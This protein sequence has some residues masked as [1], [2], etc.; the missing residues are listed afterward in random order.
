RRMSSAPRVECGGEGFQ[1]TTILHCDRQR[2]EAAV[3]F[4]LLL[5]EAQL[6]LA[7]EHR[8]LEDIGIKGAVAH[9]SMIGLRDT[10]GAE[11]PFI[12]AQGTLQIGHGEF[13]VMNA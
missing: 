8:C 12:E 5:I 9:S 1:G 6:Y 7:A 3:L 11:K 2:I 10:F 4:G 13:E